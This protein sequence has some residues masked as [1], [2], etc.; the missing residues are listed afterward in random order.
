MLPTASIS[1]LAE[2]FW[3]RMA[4]KYPLSFDPQTYA[5][6]VS[7]LGLVQ[8]HGVD[9]KGATVLDIGCGP[10]IHALPL[11]RDFGAAVTAL[12]NSVGMLAVMDQQINAHG[13]RGVRPFRAFWRDLDIVALGFEQA[14]D[15]V[16]ASMTPAVAGLEDFVSMERCSRQWCGYVG[17]GRKQANVLFEEVFAAH[18]LNLVGLPGAPA[19]YKALLHAG[20]RPCIDYFESAWDWCGTPDELMANILDYYE[21]LR[22]EP[23]RLEIEKILKAHERD[24]LIRHAT[25][26]EEGLLVWRADR[27]RWA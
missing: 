17:W 14:F 1:G 15:V 27:Q 25:V 10:G 19:A 11:A 12:D 7:L 13:V 6:T 21:L 3:N 2:A 26:V 18:G 24:G 9:F 4:P 22:V 23:R 5:Q 20:R 8:Q 16:W